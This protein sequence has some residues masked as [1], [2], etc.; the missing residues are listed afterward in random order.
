MIK[1]D[2]IMF[3]YGDV[4]VASSKIMSYIEFVNIKPP[5]EI[6]ICLDVV[7]GIEYGLCV[8][9]KEDN[10]FDLYKLIKTVTEE[11]NIVEFK[12]YVLDFSN[13]NSKSIDVV[14]QHARNMVNTMV[15]AC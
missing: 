2:R 4:A 13:Y 5:Q 12:G 3:G 14:L 9:L 1:G 10:S 7:E 15:L 6:G 8:R 11:N